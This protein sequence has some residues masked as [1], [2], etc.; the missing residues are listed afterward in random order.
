MIDHPKITDEERG[1]RRKAIDTARAS[2]RLEG[3]VLDEGS[4]ALFAR[5]VDGEMTRP[6]L[7]EAVQKLAASYG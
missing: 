7:N 5:Y 3:L 1:R 4:E 2:V 6:E